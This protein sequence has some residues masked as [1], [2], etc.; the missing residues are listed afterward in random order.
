MIEHPKEVMAR[1]PRYRELMCDLAN[2]F[3]LE[4]MQQEDPETHRKIQSGLSKPCKV[5]VDMAW[6]ADAYDKWKKEEDVRWKT[7]MAMFLE[8]Q[9]A[10]FMSMTKEEQAAFFRANREKIDMTTERVRRRT[11]YTGP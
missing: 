3:W 1:Y 2:G 8:L 6:D 7:A 5:F 10:N 4:I 9:P 11:R